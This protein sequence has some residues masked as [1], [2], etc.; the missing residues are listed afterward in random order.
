[1]AMF[2]YPTSSALIYPPGGGGGSVVSVNGQTGVVQLD[3]VDIPYDNTTSGLTAT[4]VQAAI[5]ELATAVDATYTSETF[6]LSAPE[7]AAQEV[8]LSETPILANKTI[9]MVASAPSQFYGA[10]FSVT[11]NVL[12]WAGL[13]LDSLLE[14]GDQLTIMYI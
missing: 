7:A 13:G 2:T 8:T 5:D 9:L 11:G 1:M 3:A 12:S 10:D 14:T 4:E 6:T